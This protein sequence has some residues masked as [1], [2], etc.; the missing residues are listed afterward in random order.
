[1]PKKPAPKKKLKRGTTPKGGRPTKWTPKMNTLIVE[2]FKREPTREVE[3]LHKNKK[4]EEYTT[5]EDKPN[6]I[7]TF[8]EFADSVDVSQDTLNEWAKPENAAKYPGFSAAHKKAHELQ[9]WFIIE[10][11]MNGR[12]NATF[13]IFTAKNITDMRDVQG[14]EHTGKDGEKLSVNIITSNGHTPNT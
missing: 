6:K 11:A 10:N 5:F 12:Y 1:M 13:A 14:V 4:G 3:V 9:K 7:P 8:L 2:Y